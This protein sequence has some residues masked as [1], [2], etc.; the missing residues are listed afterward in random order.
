M[1]ETG[2]WAVTVESSDPH[3]TI[4]CDVGNSPWQ[5]YVTHLPSMCLLFAFSTLLL[6]SILAQPTHLKSE[7][8]YISMMCNVY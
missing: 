6:L 5:K 4:D 8:N 2:H 1:V 3:G 7:V